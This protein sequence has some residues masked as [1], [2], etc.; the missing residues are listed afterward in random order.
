MP[1]RR[2]RV[3]FS[4]QPTSIPPNQTVLIEAAVRS[5]E[6]GRNDVRTNED[7]H[8][9][10]NEDIGLY[11]GVE[12][13]WDEFRAFTVAVATR[14]PDV[15]VRGVTTSMRAAPDDLNRAQ[16]LIVCFGAQED[17]EM[18]I[19][20]LNHYLRRATGRADYVVAMGR[21]PVLSISG[22]VRTDVEV[23]VHPTTRPLPAVW[24]RFRDP[25]FTAGATGF[26][27]VRRIEEDPAA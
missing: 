4:L 2:P 20:R 19:H 17:P 6:A 22:V 12:P 23:V 26:D 15:L 14:S 10:E 21:I 18:Y 7:P 13:W 8:F 1:E 24:L 11:E 16:W 25:R 3:D 9:R 27:L 5:D